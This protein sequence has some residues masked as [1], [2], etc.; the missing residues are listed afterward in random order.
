MEETDLLTEQDATLTGGEEQNYDI[1][2]DL[3]RGHINTIILRCLYDGDKYGYEII[4]DIEK[5]SG[6]LYTIK[7][8]TLYS[9][10]KRLEKLRY[11]TSYHGEFSNGGQ[12]KY[13]SLTDLGK[14]VTEQNLSDWEYSRTIIDSLI[15]DGNAHY[16]FSF[17]TEK[18]KELVDLKATLSAREKALNDEKIALNNLRN[19]LQ[20]ERS[21]LSAQSSS[22]SS[23]KTDFKELQ[24]QIENQKRELEAQ[25]QALNE[26]QGEIDVKEL[27][28]AEKEQEIAQ[29]KTE[30]EQQNA[31]ILSL[32]E[33]L[34]KQQLTFNEESALELSKLQAENTALATELEDKKAVILSLNS[35]IATQENSLQ[36]LK[37]EYE[38]KSTEFYNRS[39]ELRAQQ[40]QFDAQKEKFDEEKRANAEET[41]RLNALQATLSDKEHELL[42]REKAIEA[43]HE[44]N[45]VEAL[46]ALENER[47]ELKTQLEI[48][49]VERNTLRSDN[50]A[51]EKEKLALETE[52]ERLR[53]LQSALQSEREQIDKKAYEITQQEYK[54]ST[55]QR[56]LESKHL[57]TSESAEE[58]QRQ[59]SDLERRENEL[60]S[61]SQTLQDDLSVLQQQ[62]KELSARQTVYNQQQLEFIARKNALSAQQFELAEK[63]TSYNSQVKLFN[64]NLEK[65]ENER[66]ALQNERQKHEN[67]VRA[68]AQ[69]KETFEIEKQKFAEEKSENEKERMDA[70]KKALDDASGLQVR[71]AELQERERAI[72]QRENALHERLMDFQ[73]RGVPQYYDQY[74][75][76]VGGY[77][78]SAPYPT[79][80][81]GNLRE[82]AQSDGIRL[83]TAGTMRSYAQNNVATETAYATAQTKSAGRFYNVGATL[84]KSA[85]IVFCI[86]AFECLLV[87]F[88]KEWLQISAVYPI[89][90]FL[91][92]F[93][94]FLICSILYA[95]GYRSRVRRKKHPSYVLTNTVLF[96]ISV[97]VVSM[98]AVYCKAQISVLPELLAFIVIPVGYLLN[99]LIF[100]AF[101]Y[102]FSKRNEK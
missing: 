65:M 84:F 6:G 2:S 16:D 35:A 5:K 38:N 46:S 37:S 47:A 87:F 88:A 63:L 14:Q 43:F 23:Q 52:R 45:D 78:P 11:V 1:S 72:T 60:Y 24:T 70:Q 25:H 76:G 17:I 44:T 49:E 4:A 57:E 71:M 34:E 13:F 75:G 19:E 8:P 12:R 77:A 96:V 92:G 28:L 29:A 39:L 9:A 55:Q 41:E 7:Q 48:L 67:D 54:V 27:E 31:E 69:E 73:T 18:Q 85:F 58:L 98:I 53:E 40:A 100:T 59:A 79:D 51:L 3:I 15:S 20:R 36:L 50:E 99:I 83:N 33:M 93:I 86:I 74:V 68:L 80:P 10:L 101:F 21:L 62:Q 81:Y 56:E 22:L 61:R 82:Q 89:V 91:G 42:D 64:E 90:G 26:K 95:C 66:L 32:K 30:L 102:T 94:V 97:I